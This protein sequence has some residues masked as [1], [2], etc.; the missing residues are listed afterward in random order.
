M[1]KVF[2]FED[3]ELLADKISSIKKKP[4]LIDIRDII[5]NNNPNIL[6]TENTNGLYL[7]FNNLTQNTYNNLEN[8]LT[9][10]KRKKDVISDTMSI[11]PINLTNKN[12][13]Y[14]DG[15]TRLKYN[16]KEKNILKRIIYDKTIQSE[17]ES[18]EGIDIFNKKN[19]NKITL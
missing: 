2:E 7:Y 18:Y 3:I 10:N 14:Y 15:N 8:Y 17:E 1:S 19:I 4:Q 11:S 16:N 9:K 13:C 6:I 5:I 12:D